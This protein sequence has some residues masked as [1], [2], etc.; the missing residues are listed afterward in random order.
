MNTRRTAFSP[1][2]LAAPWHVGLDLLWGTHHPH[3]ELGW[4]PEP[5]AC[6]ESWL[7]SGLGLPTQAMRK[8]ASCPRWPC[9]RIARAR[10]NGGPR[11]H[12]SPFPCVLSPWPWDPRSPISSQRP[13][14]PIPSLE[15]Q[16]SQP[17]MTA[18]CPPAPCIPTQDGGDFAPA[19]TRPGPRLGEGDRQS[20]PCYCCY[21][22]GLFRR[23]L[24]C[25][26]LVPSLIDQCCNLALC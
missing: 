21:P 18:L 5:S 14:A 8:A 7:L 23:Q 26:T 2:R 4:D 1:S 19:P 16:A 12:S 9:Q 6:S 3:R 17:G 13:L 15:E 10:R 11:V 20:S 22:W 24:I 25:F